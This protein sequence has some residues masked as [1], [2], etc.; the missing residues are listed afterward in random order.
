MNQVNRH[1]DHDAT[2]LV[3]RPT[4]IPTPRTPERLFNGWGVR[5]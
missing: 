5:L 2:A 3:N 4:V 1:P